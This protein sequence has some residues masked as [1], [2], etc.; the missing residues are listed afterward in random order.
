VD[1]GIILMEWLKEWIVEKVN[2]KFNLAIVP[3]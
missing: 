1:G 2:N 3:G